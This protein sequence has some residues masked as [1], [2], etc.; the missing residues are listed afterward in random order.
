M[1]TALEWALSPLLALKFGFIGM[2]YSSALISFTSIIPI[3]IIKKIINVEIL[4]NIWQPIIASVFMALTIF[5]LSTLFPPRS[6][7]I[8]G[9]ILLGGLIYMGLLFLFA[10]EK[11]KTNLRELINALFNR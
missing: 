8:L 3:L 11:I 1:W 9:M 6:I 5:Y 2:G 7:F 10:R 4:D